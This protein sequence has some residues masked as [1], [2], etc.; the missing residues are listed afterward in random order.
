MYIGQKINFFFLCKIS[1]K[2][3]FVDPT[4]LIS[5]FSSRKKE[6]LVFP[7]K[8]HSYIG[9]KYDEIGNKIIF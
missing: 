4:I 3:L 5:P 9:C 2:I 8:L 6:L 1:L 7:K